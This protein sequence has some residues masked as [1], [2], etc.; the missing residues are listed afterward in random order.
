MT[1]MDPE[2]EDDLTGYR[3]LAEFPDYDL[4]VNDENSVIQRFNE[5]I[6]NSWEEF[7]LDFSFDQQEMANLKQAILLYE[8]SDPIQ[9]KKIQKEIEVQILGVIDE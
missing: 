5:G 9:A 2:Y 1:I 7:D 6:A 4:Y 8:N 3:L